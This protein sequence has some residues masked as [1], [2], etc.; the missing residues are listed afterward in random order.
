MRPVNLIPTARREAARRRRYIR[1]WVGACIAYACV[2][3]LAYGA[4]HLFWRPDH[5]TRNAPVNLRKL[6]AANQETDKA[7]KEVQAKLQDARRTLD[8]NRAV[9]EKPDWS[10][11]MVLLTRTLEDQ[12]VLRRCNLVPMVA[13]PVPASVAVA[14]AP[15]ATGGPAVKLAAVAAAAPPPGQ[16]YTLLLAGLGK[17]QTSVTQFV[18]R[19]ERTGLFDEVKLISAA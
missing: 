6:V 9:V 5:V 15:R 3:G 8:A 4:L 18:V 19:L 13:P 17:T 2:L 14:P 7:V 11:L 10:L 16:Q 1:R 12:I